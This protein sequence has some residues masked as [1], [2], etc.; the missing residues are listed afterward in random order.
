MIFKKPLKL[1]G[2]SGL[3]LFLFR[4]EEALLISA[5]ISPRSFPISS[6]FSDIFS[7]SLYLVNVRKRKKREKVERNLHR[8]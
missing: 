7:A 6:N 2:S 5:I 1:T 4:A 8:M 3:V